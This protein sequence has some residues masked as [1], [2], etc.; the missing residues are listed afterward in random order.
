MGTIA[1]GVTVYIKEARPSP[2]ETHSMPIL[3][4]ARRWTWRP[5]KA[6]RSQPS[7]WTSFPP[8]PT[9]KRSIMRTEASRQ[10][11][12]VFF[13]EQ[14]ALQPPHPH[15]R[16]QNSCWFYLHLSWLHLGPHPPTACGASSP[17]RASPRRPCLSRRFL[18][19][20]DHSSQPQ[21]G[22]RAP[23]VYA[24]LSHVYPVIPPIRPRLLLPLAALSY[25]A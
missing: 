22:G 23:A 16:V 2:R 25:C 13:C 12:P 15:P 3:H 7:R 6:P 11:F 5:A 20:P 9:W 8:G 1:S 18:I 21:Q 24:T 17:S 4:L 10:S 19:S 14:Q